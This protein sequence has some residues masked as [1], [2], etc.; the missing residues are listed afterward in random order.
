M[1]I[2]APSCAARSSD[3]PPSIP[4]RKPA[5]KPSPTPVGSTLP[6]RG[7]HADL[8]GGAVAAGDLARPSRCGVVIRMSTRS[9]DL[10][11]GPARLLQQQLP[12][13]VVAEQVAGAVDEAADLRALHAGQ[14]LGRVGGERDPQLAAL[15]GVPEHAVG[16]VGADQHHVETA[17]GA[18]APGRSPGPAPS[19][20]RRTT[21]SGACRRRWCRRTGRSARRRRPARPSS[22]RR[23]R[24]ARRGTRRS[25][26][27]RRR[28][29]AGRGRARR[30]RTRCCRPTPPRLMTRSSTRKVSETRS[31]WSARS[32]SANRPGKCMRWSVAM[33]PVTAM[34]TSSQPTGW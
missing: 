1:A 31:S 11:L 16:V 22:R 6:R 3:S 5:R 23:G 7:H 33:D 20:R 34:G 17:L 14:L 10:R 21:R 27:R 26:R 29:A 12:L 2:S 8:Q 13:V 25:R 18:A 9:R 4:A 19:R 15:V 28:R 32:W 24:S 30:A